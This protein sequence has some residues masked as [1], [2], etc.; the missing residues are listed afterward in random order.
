[1]R[2]LFAIVRVLCLCGRCQFMRSRTRPRRPTATATHS[3]PYGLRLRFWRPPLRNRAPIT[4]FGIEKDGT[5]VTVGPGADVR[6]WNPAD[7]KSEE[8]IRLPLKGTENSYNLPQVSPDGKLVAAC[9]NEKVFVWDAPTDP[10]RITEGSGRV[11]DSPAT[12]DLFRSLTRCA[13]SS[14]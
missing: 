9:S 13:P 7:D 5:V 4:G 10:K 12:R 14:S 1:M 6:R 8:P 11:R 2:T 3:H